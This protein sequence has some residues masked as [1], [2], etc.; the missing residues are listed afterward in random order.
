MVDAAAAMHCAA[1][2]ADID[3]I[4]AVAAMK[5]DQLHIVSIEVEVIGIGAH[6]E[7]ESAKAAC[8]ELHGRGFVS[9][10]DDQRVDAFATV[11]AVGRVAELAT[12]QVDH[13]I[14]GTSTYV[15]GL[16]ACDDLVIAAA[17]RERQAFDRGNL[18]VATINKTVREP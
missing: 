13:V 10:I 8:P 3:R 12:S 2:L 16:I 15:V 9:G 18:N 7:A 1:M 17:G 5:I 4:V 11:C 14:A 6:E